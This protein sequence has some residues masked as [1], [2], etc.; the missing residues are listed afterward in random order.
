MNNIIKKYMSEIGKKGGKRNLELY[1]VA[2]FKMI[3]KKGVKKRQE[4]KLSTG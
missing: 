3:S 4:K 1:G 2:Y